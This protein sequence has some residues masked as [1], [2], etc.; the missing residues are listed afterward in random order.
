MP[1]LEG[2]PVRVLLVEAKP[3]SRAA[4]SQMLR[5]AGFEVY[6]FETAHEALACVLGDAPEVVVTDAA[7]ALEQLG[8]E[9]LALAFGGES[10]LLQA[11]LLA[12]TADRVGE[13]GLR[14]LFSHPNSAGF[15]GARF[16][17]AAARAAARPPAS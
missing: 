7:A 15:A 14:L 5:S 6:P 2:R 8:G 1:A 17:I 4:A 9:A 10:P 3:A 12:V 11:A 13:T 16:V